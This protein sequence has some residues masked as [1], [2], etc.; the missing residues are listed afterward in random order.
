MILSEGRQTHFAHVIIDGLYDDDLVDYTDD[1]AAM[2]A[3]KRA[4]QNFLKEEDNIDAVVRQKVMSL[5]KTVIEGSTEWDTMYGKYYEEEL[6][7]R[8][9]K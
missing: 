4:V 8:G 3:A 2:R 1:D 6:K 7:K 9:L 5:K